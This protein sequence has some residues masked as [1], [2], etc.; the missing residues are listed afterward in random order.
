MPPLGLRRG[1]DVAGG[2][3]VSKTPG[4]RP[5]VNRRCFGTLLSEVSDEV[6]RLAGLLTRLAGGPTRGS[7][8]CLPFVDLFP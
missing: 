1:G 8:A 7:L 2:W 4:Q 6:G 3:P 5:R